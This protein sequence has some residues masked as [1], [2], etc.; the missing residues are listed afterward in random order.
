[1]MNFNLL[2]MFLIFFSAEIWIDE[3]TDASYLVMVV[4]QR[5][6]FI[7]ILMRLWKLYHCRDFC[8][9][10]VTQGANKISYR[11]T[12]VYSSSTRYNYGEIISCAIMKNYEFIIFISVTYPY[13]LCC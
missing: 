3:W 12:F 8:I 5:I 4:Q 1:M 11:S 10:K 2:P 9:N 7:V 6:H 13:L